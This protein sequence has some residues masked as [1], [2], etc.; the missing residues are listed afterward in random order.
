MKTMYR[1]ASVAI[2]GSSETRI[3]RLL[4]EWPGHD[5][6]VYR[7][8]WFAFESIG[9]STTMDEMVEWVFYTFNQIGKYDYHM[10]DMGLRIYGIIHDRLPRNHDPAYVVELILEVL[11]MLY[12][13][14]LPIY[15]ALKRD[16]VRLYVYR[17]S[18]QGV[19]IEVHQTSV[20][21]S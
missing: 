12:Y 18:N 4:F 9:L 8:Y 5:A 6:K 1:N 2:L 7:D 16:G 15:H 14:F 21:T 19:V 11:G 3:R 10:T 17:V 13:D 20:T